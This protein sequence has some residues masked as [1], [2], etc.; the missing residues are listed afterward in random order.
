VSQ[1]IISSRSRLSARA[2]ASVVV[3]SMLGLLS[4]LCPRT[5]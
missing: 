4:L 5:A 3:S 1:I 2:P